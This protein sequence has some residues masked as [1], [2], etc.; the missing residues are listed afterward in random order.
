MSDKNL[1]KIGIVAAIMAVLAIVVSIPRT[2][3]VSEIVK[4]TPL[5]QGMN[6]T[7]IAAIEVEG[8]GKKARLEKN[9]DNFVVANKDNYPA[10]IENVNKLIVDCLDIKVEDM[11]TD[12]P[13]NHTELEVLESNA[14]HIVKFFDKDNKLITGIVVG[15][16]D[17]NGAGVYVRKLSEKPEEA[18]RVYLAPKTAWLQAN[19]ISYVQKKLLECE[20]K[21][22]S[23]VTVTT[24]EGS[25]SVVAKLKGENV[26]LSL[27]NIPEGKQ[28]KGLE[29]E[30]VFG[31]ATNIEF[32]DIKK[33]SD[34]DASVK[35]DYSYVILCAD[36]TELT[37]KIA[38]SS[39]AGQDKYYVKCFSEY[40]NKEFMDKQKSGSISF[41]ASSKESMEELDNQ[42]QVY[43]STQEFN[44]RHKDWVYVLESWKAGSMVKSFSELIEDIP[45]VEDKEPEDSSGQKVGPQPSG[46]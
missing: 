16:R 31:A 28:A 34:I 15:K 44:A 20:K 40:K 38:K 35:F 25:Y 39:E 1:M 6:T 8:S 42:I 21:D 13:D 27:P 36:Q 2:E 43:Q 45:Q 9:G 11:V 17:D 5:I 37:L 12:N 41:D 29:Y 23:S 3:K 7:D 19:P 10:L 30:S 32:S 33:V 46:Q 4:D 18:A 24:P 26:D 22:V 14:K